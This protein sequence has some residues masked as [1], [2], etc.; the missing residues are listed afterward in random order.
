MNSKYQ[1]SYLN[2]EYPGWYLFGNKAFGKKYV[3]EKP[4]HSTSFVPKRK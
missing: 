3:Y 2:T 4:E 1:N